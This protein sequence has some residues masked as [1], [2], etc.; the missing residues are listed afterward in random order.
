MSI[1]ISYEDHVRCALKTF[2][3][4]MM[5]A[6]FAA[7]A[8]VFATCAAAEME[9]VTDVKITPTPKV[10]REL[11]NGVRDTEGDTSVYELQ[12][13]LQQLGYLAAEPDGIYG[14]S[15]EVAVKEFQE[16]NGIRDTGVADL[17]T[18]LLLFSDI[19]SI[20]PKPTPTPTPINNGA[21]GEDVKTAQLALA[22]WGFLSG[23]ADGDYGN[24]TES[25]VKAYKNYIYALEQAYLEAHPTP[26]P[27][28][29]PTPTPQPTPYVADGEQPIVVDRTVEPTP[30][31][32]PSPTPYAPDGLIDD[33]LLAAFSQESFQVYVQDLASGDKG[34]EVT[35]LQTRL[36]NLGYLY[37]G[38]DG[39]FG[40]MTARALKYFQQRNGLEETGVADEITQRIL[41]SDAAERSTEYV[42]PYKLIVDVSEQKVYV[43]EWTGSRYGNCVKTMTCSTGTKSNPTPLGTYQA[44]GACGGEWYYFKDFDCYAKYAYRI[45]G[46]ILFHSVLYNSK[47]ESSLSRSSVN[48]LGSRA[49]HGCVRLT[50]ENAKWICNN[51]PAG[52]TVVIQK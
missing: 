32:T 36:W 51:C 18:Q 47:S 13:R 44:G 4:M 23:S 21:S 10:Y 35:R 49:S 52:T 26:T 38:A 2:G 39:A 16:L 43:Y 42:F 29:T 6:L 19:A 34:R 46:G 40:G 48:A 22:R 37:G 45:I 12:V 17:D 31:V 41:F 5:A 15:T 33:D 9:I 30:E 14:A 25:A 27:A 50:V 24:R 11:L 28:P 20:V 7:I 1:Q 8:L 3:R